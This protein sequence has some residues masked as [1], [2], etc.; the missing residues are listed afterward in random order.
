MEKGTTGTINLCNPGYISHNE[1][2]K[3]YGEIVDPLFKW[4]NFTQEEQR[5]ILAADRSNNFLETDKL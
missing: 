1:I 3:M 2:L 4:E 5:K